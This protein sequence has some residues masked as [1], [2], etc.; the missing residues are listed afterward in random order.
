MTVDATSELIHCRAGGTSLLLACTERRL[1]YVLYWGRDLGELKDDELAA[2]GLT[3]RPQLVPNT[4]DRDVP[5]GVIP[6]PAYGWMGTPGLSGHRD[7]SAFSAARFG[8][9]M[10]SSPFYT[11]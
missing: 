9:V 1:P 10:G 8:M 7:G 11:V 4:V 5:V 3:Q 2:F 6:E